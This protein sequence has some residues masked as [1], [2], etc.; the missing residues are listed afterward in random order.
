M[1][2]TEGRVSMWPLDSLGGRGW[3]SPAGGSRGQLARADPAQWAGLGRG[4]GRVVQTPVRSW[5]AA[6]GK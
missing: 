4:R 1:G 2:S 6:A 5:M 3:C